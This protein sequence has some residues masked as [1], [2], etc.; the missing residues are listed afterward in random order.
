VGDMGAGIPVSREGEC[1]AQ[2]KQ[3]FVAGSKTLRLTGLQFSADSQYDDFN[4]HLTGM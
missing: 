1:R 2:W 4:I 3:H